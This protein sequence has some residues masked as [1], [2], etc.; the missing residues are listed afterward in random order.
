M[1]GVDSCGVCGGASDTC[2]LSITLN[3]AVPPQV[4]A[5]PLS[6]L[7]TLF[8]TSPVGTAIATNV[9]TA[10]AAVI[11]VPSAA[12]QVLRVACA[13]SG[14]SRRLLPSHT[15]SLRGG[16]ERLVAGRAVEATSTSDASVLVRV[17]PSPQGL[18]LHSPTIMSS[19]A[20]VSLTA[21]SP[22]RLLLDRRVR[23]LVEGDPATAPGSGT[24]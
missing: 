14:G 5:T 11:N 7:E 3:I 16:G 1:I 20:A 4:C 24:C 22:Q 13:V 9:S 17:L 6:A 8:L 23:G 19:L 15:G 18:Q 2:G 12:V 21:P 10:V